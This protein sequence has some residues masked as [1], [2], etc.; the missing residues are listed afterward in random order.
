MRVGLTKLRLTVLL[1]I[2]I[3]ML[4]LTFTYIPT[5]ILMLTLICTY[6]LTLL[7]MYI[8]IL[9][10]ILLLIFLYAYTFLYAYLNS[11]KYACVFCLHLRTITIFNFKYLESFS[12]P[13]NITAS[14]NKNN[15]AKAIRLIEYDFQDFFFLMFSGTTMHFWSSSM[16]FRFWFQVSKPP[17]NLQW[18]RITTTLFKR[19]WMFSILFPIKDYCL[20]SARNAKFFVG[21][22]P[23]KGMPLTSLHVVNKWWIPR[24]ILMSIVALC[25]HTIDC[26]LK[27]A[28]F[29]SWTKSSNNVKNL[30]NFWRRTETE[31]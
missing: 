11:T 12:Y 9:M 22:K 24:K 30:G 4:V 7:V 3:L 21:L 29:S 26:L 25:K 23:K 14:F 13:R 8:L 31:H 5:F 1:L 16:S 18:R 15:L 28:L 6:N 20:I 19:F 2:P 27:T 17:T 10:H